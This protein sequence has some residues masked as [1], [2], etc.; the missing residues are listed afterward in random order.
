MKDVHGFGTMI[1]LG[2]AV[3]WFWIDCLQIW[4]IVSGNR[5]LWMVVIK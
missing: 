3:K 4:L 1:A 5:E 2:M